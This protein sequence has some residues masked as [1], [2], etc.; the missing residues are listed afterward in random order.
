MFWKKTAT[1]AALSLNRKAEIKEKLEVVSKINE[2]LMVAVRETQATSVELIKKLKSELKVAKKSLTSVCEKLKDGVLLADHTGA[3]IQANKAVETM[4][5]AKVIGRKLD[6]LVESIATLDGKKLDGIKFQFTPEFFGD[7]SDKLLARIEAGCTVST[8][9][10]ICNRCLS[11]QL[12]SHFNLTGDV[13]LTACLNCPGR[14]EVS[15][16]F[17]ILD[18]DPESLAD[19]IYIIVI[20]DH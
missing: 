3:V 1:V 7:L 18:N 5:G 17:S 11:E 14:P 19:L 20:R 9:H 16:S 15:F 13:T 2:Q 6:E 10:N 8:K 4:I 12:L